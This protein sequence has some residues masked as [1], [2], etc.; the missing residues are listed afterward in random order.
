[1]LLLIPPARQTEVQAIAH[2][3]YS[4]KR[5][6]YT[7]RSSKSVVVSPIIILTRFDEI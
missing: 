2:I 4:F 3:V 1:M 6:T 7:R 5:F